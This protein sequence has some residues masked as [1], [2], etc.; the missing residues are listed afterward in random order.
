MAIYIYIYVYTLHNRK[1]FLLPVTYFSMNLDTLLLYEQQV[2]NY[3]MNSTNAYIK[4]CHLI[5]GAFHLP[6]YGH[7]FF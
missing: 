7:V 3:K 1:R 6:I 4:F 5:P 2:Q